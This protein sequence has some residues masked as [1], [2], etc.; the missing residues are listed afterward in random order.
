MAFKYKLTVLIS[1]L[2]VLVLAGGFTTTQKLLES[3]F[4]ERISVELERTGKIVNE[5]MLAQTRD[6]DQIAEI[7]QRESLIVEGLRS[8]GLDRPTWDNTLRDELLLSRFS[9]LEAIVLLDA[10]GDVVGIG[11]NGIE[12][13][14]VGHEFSNPD[15]FEGVLEADRVLAT[16]IHDAKQNRIAMQWVGRPILDVDVILG[17]VFVGNLIDDEF[18]NRVKFLSG[19]ELMVVH[20]DTFNPL[21]A[22]DMPW[23]KSHELSSLGPRVET[24]LQ[25]DKTHKWQFQD[26]RVL[27][28]AGSDRINLGDD[29]ATILVSRFPPYLM[30]KSLDREMKFVRTIRSAVLAIG[31][32]AVLIAILLG[33]LLSRGISRP[34]DAL[35]LATEAIARS[36][37]D[38][39]VRVSSHDEFERLADAFNGMAQGLQ[40]RERIRGAMNKVVSKEIAD[41]LL[42]GEIKLGGESRQATVLFSDIR[43]FTSLAEGMNPEALLDLLNAYFTRA[44]ACVDRHHGIIDKYIGDAVMALFGVPVSRPQSALDAVFAARDMISALEKFNLEFTGL[45]G[46]LIRIGIGINTGLVVAGNVGSDQ[47]LNY[48]VL[49]DEVNLASRLEGLTAKYGVSVIVSESTID[50]IG[51]SESIKFRRLDRVQVKGK[52]QGVQIYDLASGKAAAFIAAYESAWDEMMAGQF[53]DARDAFSDLVRDDP[54]DHVSEIMWRRCQSYVDSEAGF[55]TDYPQGSFIFTSK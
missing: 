43:G 24:I 6:I 19:V 38:H 3:R 2:V 53:E 35:Q 5:V 51:P 48:T 34:I 33:F 21:L 15:Y 22:T 10:N 13:R 25:E 14:S 26:D 12:S 9:S 17:A 36:E 18:I 39:R 27:C 55:K 23:L 30:M 42:K 8:Y 4:S 7:L 28:R 40:E 49:G 41:E 20:P 44:S 54:N 52:K 32:V 11:A 47:R 37:F 29:V 31:L 16:S 1:V 50:A 46:R 45:A